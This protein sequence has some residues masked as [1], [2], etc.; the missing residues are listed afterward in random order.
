MP[1]LD[2]TSPIK[3]SK[4]E[5]NAS[6]SSRDWRSSWQE[7]PNK[8]EAKGHG[9]QPLR[10]PRRGYFTFMLCFIFAAGTQPLPPNSSLCSIRGT[11]SQDA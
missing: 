8:K 4:A 10:V 9:D 5:F 2:T 11:L 6:D 1:S 3:C 7:L